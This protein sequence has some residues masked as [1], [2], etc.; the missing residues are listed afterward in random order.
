MFEYW[1]CGLPVIASNLP[2]IRPFLEDMRNGLLFD[3][4]SAEDLARA[5]EWL[6]RHPEEA[7]KMGQYGQEQI[8]RTWNN[9]RQ[10][11]TLI[12]L[13]QKICARKHIPAK[14]SDC[15]EKSSIRLS[16]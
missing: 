10:I 16:T 4:T 14:P 2:P 12:G 11:D 5:I 3:P 1:A 15:L 6:V 7:K 9:D 13:Y 8:Q